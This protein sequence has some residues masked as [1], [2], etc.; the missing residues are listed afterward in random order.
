MTVS[1]TLNKIIYSGNGATTVFPFTFPGV[2]ATNI[3]VFFTDA[4]GNITLLSPSVYTLS[5]TPATGTNPTGA[6]GSV[7][8]NPLGVPIP[9]G[10]FLT[11]LRTLPLVQS[12]SL[13]NQGTLYQ[14]VEEAALDYEMMVSQQVLE[15]QSRALVV[16]VSDPTPA[17]IPAVAARKGLFLAFDSSGNPIAAAPGGASTPVSSA[18]APVVAAATLAA[19]RAAFGLGA[20]ATEGIGAGLQDDGAGN[21]RVNLAL[22]TDTV[23]QSVAAGFDLTRRQAL[24]SITYTFP[25][26]S[27]L[28]ANFGF[29]ISTRGFS[30]T[31]APNAADAFDGAATGASLILPPGITT[32]V[33]TNATGTWYADLGQQV[34]LNSPLNLQINAS[35]ATNALTIALKDRNGNDPTPVSP[36]IIA[37]RDPT[38]ANGDLVI[39]AITT[40]LSITI[41]STATIGT[42]N[43]QANRLWVG[44]FDNAGTPVLGVYNSLNSTGPSIDCWDETNVATGTAIAGASNTP[45]TWYTNGTVTSK[46]F[47]VI[48]FVESTQATA[49]TWA[50]TPS[51]VALFGPGVKRPGETITG[52]I[53]KTNST[54]NTTTSA[55]FVVLTNSEISITPSSAANLIRVRAAG[56]MSGSNGSAIN[57]QL[58]RGT[59]AATNMIGS[60]NE[61]SAAGIAGSITYMVA[62]VAY[63]IPNVTTSIT[64]AVQGNAASAITMTFPVS[65]L[66]AVMEIEEIQ[67]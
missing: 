21:L 17:A 40:P 8:Y 10:S 32:F 14:P 26:S 64:Y 47:R 24:A 33:Q 49:G 29:W 52:P 66:A 61:G 48:G 38:I 58:S 3:Q 6:G 43:A 30:I 42:V 55:S 16:P 31:L 9:T 50:T 20:A 27:T 45:Q 44:L 1:T 57:A 65:G 18:M 46:A 37:F 2:A 13:A 34:G 67:I 4:L 35:V 5:L 56:T 28:F 22:V 11:I 7:T 63:D 62:L 53:A 12:T 39:R 51:K 60:I 54:A 23:N 59:V 36:A 19:A 41:P 25:L 15:I